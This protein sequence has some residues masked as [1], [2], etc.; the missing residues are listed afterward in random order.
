MLC[1]CRNGTSCRYYK[2]GRC[3]FGH[4]PPDLKAELMTQK[5]TLVDRYVQAHGAFVE[6]CCRD[7][8]ELVT[9]RS[10][11]EL[12]L[13]FDVVERSHS[14]YCSDPGTADEKT[15][16]ADER[17]PIPYGFPIDK[18]DADGCVEPEFLSKVYDRSRGECSKCRV[19]RTLKSVRL[20]PKRLRSHPLNPFQASLLGM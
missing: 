16:S 13:R 8:W 5:I 17:L 2:S 11:Y 1:L 7:Y 19:T 20:H 12:T 9:E 14:G 15:Y 10:P 18:V 6:K 3:H 4:P